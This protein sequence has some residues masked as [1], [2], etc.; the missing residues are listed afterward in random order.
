VYIV[1]ACTVLAFVYVFPF[2]FFFSKGF[3][4]LAVAVTCDKIT[5]DGNNKRWR[6]DARVSNIIVRLRADYR[7]MYNLIE[8]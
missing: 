3:I 6:R 7:L 4:T 1:F 8:F 5:N 2:Y